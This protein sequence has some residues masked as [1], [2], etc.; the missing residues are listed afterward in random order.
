MNVIA[1]LKHT[2]KDHEHI[3]FWSPDHR[4]YT[5]VLERAGVYSEA[6][7]AKLNDGVDYIA[8]PVNAALALS[9]PTPYFKPGAQFYDQAG[10][11]VENTRANWNALVKASIEA[12]RDC[13]KPKP[14]VFRGKRRCIPNESAK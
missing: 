7:S 6:E 1:S 3:T 8:I 2:I 13:A 5:P 9:I 10:C 11:V 14:E 4:G 12:G